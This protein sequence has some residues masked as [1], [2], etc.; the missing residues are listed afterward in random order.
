MIALHVLRPRPFRDGLNALLSAMP[1]I[2]LVAQ[3]EDAGAALEFLAGRCVELALLKVDE[4]AGQFVETAA[5]MKALCPLIRLVA[6][7]E[8]EEGWQTAEMGGADPVVWLGIQASVLKAEIEALI[9]APPVEPRSSTGT[10]PHAQR[11][12]L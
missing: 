9:S 11:K 7:V 10:P 4:M 12:P 5:K 1:E 3:A 6:I 8:D 2:R